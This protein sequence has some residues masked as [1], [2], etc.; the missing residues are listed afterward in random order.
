MNTS[1]TGLGLYLTKEITEAHGGR[2]Y[3]ESEGLGKGSTFFMELD[4]IK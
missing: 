2:V 3:V 4:A 1:G